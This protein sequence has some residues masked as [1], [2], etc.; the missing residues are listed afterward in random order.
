MITYDRFSKY[1]IRKHSVDRDGSYANY[2]TG[3]W[4]WWTDFLRFVDTIQDQS[5][6][7]HF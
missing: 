4:I 3:T 1:D 6:E 5:E 2:K 7:E